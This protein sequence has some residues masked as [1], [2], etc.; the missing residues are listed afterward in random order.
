MFVLAMKLTDPGMLLLAA[1][2]VAIGMLLM[3]SSR[4]FARQNNRSASAENWPRQGDATS[5]AEMPRDVNRW[6]VQMH[7]TARQLSGQLDSK[8]AALEVLIAEADRAASRLEAAIDLSRLPQRGA[9]AGDPPGGA[10]RD[11]ASPENAPPED[12]SRGDAP[13]AD[14]ERPMA[15][16][17]RSSPKPAELPATQH[18]FREDIYA[19]ADYG[20]NPAEIAE[21][22]GSPIGE[23][24]LILSLRRKG[25]RP[26]T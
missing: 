10:S 25:P 8:M 26:T 11:S 4:Y 3:R 1:M 23:V 20:Y 13:P 12:A 14:A 17:D 9:A 24:E 19:L 18:R 21:R 15:A 5:A 6:D 2:A 22:V 16:S 7:E